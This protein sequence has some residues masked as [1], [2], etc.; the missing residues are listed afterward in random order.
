MSETRDKAMSSNRMTPALRSRCERLCEALAKVGPMDARLRYRIGVLVNGVQA[1]P[2]KYGTG[3]VEP[4][5][6]YLG[7][8]SKTLYHYAAVASR[9]TRDELTAALARRS[10]TNLPLRWSHIALLAPIA[11]SCRA[12]L[13]QAVLDDNLSPAELKRLLRDELKRRPRPRKL[14]DAV[15]VQ[16]GL[17]SVSGVLRTLKRLEA[18]CL[19]ALARADGSL[20][21]GG[22]FRVTSRRLG[23][24]ARGVPGV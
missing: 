18:D 16:R 15:I 22:L 2:A 8:G 6:R 20:R 1:S 5:G 24:P 19:P 7:Y 4:L 23:E 13:I 9:W 11:P 21:I 12:E 10:A 17:R 14:P 3:A